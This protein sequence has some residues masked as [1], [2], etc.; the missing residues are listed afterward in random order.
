MNAS[1]QKMFT[2]AL[3][4]Q[5]ADVIC[6]EIDEG[7]IP[8][9]WDGHELRLYIAQAFVQEAH[10]SRVNLSKDRLKAFRNTCIT[11]GLRY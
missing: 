4:K 10:F 7:K 9:T 6:E 8:D 11:A 3:V 2:Q 1:M 5:V